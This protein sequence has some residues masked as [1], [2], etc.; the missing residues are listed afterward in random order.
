M[1][2]PR[3][4]KHDKIHHELFDEDTSQVGS[5]GDIVDKHAGDAVFLTPDEKSVGGADGG[6]ADFEAEM[7]ETDPAESEGMDPDDLYS[8]ANER[9]L[10]QTDQTG[11]VEGIARGFGTHLPQDLGRDGFQVEEIPRRALK[12]RDQPARAEGEELDDYDDDTDT[13]KFDADPALAQASQPGANRAADP[14][15]PEPMPDRIPTRASRPASHRR[16]IGRHAPDEM[17]H[18]PARF[19]RCGLLLLLLSGAFGP[20]PLH[21]QVVPPAREITLPS[22]LP[23]GNPVLDRVW[24]RYFPADEGAQPGPGVVLIPAVGSDERDDV[25][26][27]FAEFLARRGISGAVLCLPYHGNRRIGPEL[28]SLHFAGNTIPDALHAFAQ[29]ASDVRTVTDWLA[30]QPGVDPQRLGVV[31]VSLGA[32][33]AHLAMGRDSRLRAGVA[34]LGGGDFPDLYHHSLVSRYYQ[35]RRRQRLADDALA[36][37]RAVDP[38]SDAD[39]NRPR[40]VLMIEAARDLLVPPRDALELWHALGEPPIQW[41]DTDHFALQID[42]SPAFRATAAYLW[43]VWQ[44]LPDSRIAVPRVYRPDHQIRAD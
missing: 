21:A 28:P 38:L 25:M 36:P 20:C 13:G 29:S 15:L 43:G 31:G 3:L 42:P 35:L 8:S 24:V 1:A 19:R 10:F 39:S 5:L 16:R 7:N 14:G 34:V 33:V 4:D 32:I 23:T 2:T 9:D 18:S 44:G 40:R 12:F 6:E 27:R 26:R 30:A 37:M 11:T 22:A 17:T 41:I